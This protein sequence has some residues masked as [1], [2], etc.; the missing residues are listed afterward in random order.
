MDDG[1]PVIFIE[2]MKTL[3]EARLMVDGIIVNA[4]Q[5]DAKTNIV[6]LIPEQ[7]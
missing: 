2:T 4:A 1:T 3:P 5:Y 6:T 7:G